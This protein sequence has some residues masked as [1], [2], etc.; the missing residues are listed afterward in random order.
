MVNNKI[1]DE[2][3]LLAEYKVFTESFWKNEE[4]GEKR[5]EFFITLTTAIVAGIVALFTSSSK[6]LSEASVLKIAT[7]ALSATFLFGLIT[8]FRIL[9]RNRVTEEYKGILNYLREQLKNKSKDLPEYELPFRSDKRLLKGGLAETV[10]LMNSILVGAISALWL[11][12]GW[13]WLVIPVLFLL[14]FILQVVVA[15]NDR[16]KAKDER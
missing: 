1:D 4:I 3:L 13:G 15:K 2:K 14:T 8:F 16:K 10:A 7:G 6:N 9:R 11:G 12:K 5:V